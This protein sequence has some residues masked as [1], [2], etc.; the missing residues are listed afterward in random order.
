M[1]SPSISVVLPV[2]NGEKHLKEAVDSIL[3]QSNGDFELIIVNDGSTDRT[4]FILAAYADPR[5]R[6]VNQPNGGIGEALKAGCRLAQGK[7]IARM[8]ADDVSLT[9]RFRIQAAFLDRHPSV[10]LVSSAVIY[11]DEEGKETGRS[12][13][14]TGHR[15]IRR[16]LN[17][18]NPVCHPAA[19]FRRDAY[20]RSTGYLNIQPFEDH[21]LW[22]SLAGM[23]R[24][25]NFTLPL[26]RYRVAEGS[27]SRTLTPSAMHD[28]FLFLLERLGRGGLTGKEVAEYRDRYGNAERVTAPQPAP[29]PGG[30]QMKTYHGLLRTGLP[31]RTAAGLICRVK[32]MVP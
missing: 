18:F 16:K 5:I 23:G 22:L 4:S 20:L 28:L 32:S 14:Y 21:I 13:P 30:I 31:E 3:G 8:D 10:V 19:M 24:F 27:L 15:V 12:F 26:L 17:R 9:D 7:Y 25:H 29:G 1:K 2:Y 11:M 6:I